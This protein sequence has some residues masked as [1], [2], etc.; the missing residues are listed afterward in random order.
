MQTNLFRATIQ[1]ERGQRTD[2]LV[3]GP[4]FAAVMTLFDLRS[5]GKLVCLKFEGEVILTPGTYKDFQEKFGNK[6]K[7]ACADRI[8]QRVLLEFCKG[9]LRRTHPFSVE[10]QKEIREGCARLV[11]NIQIVNSN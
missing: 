7:S 10:D 1:N 6:K 9:V 2:T 5:D 3:V 8:W 11:G 4:D